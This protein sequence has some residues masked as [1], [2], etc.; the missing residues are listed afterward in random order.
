MKKYLVNNVY[1]KAASAND[2]VKQYKMQDSVKDSDKLKQMAYTFA[3]MGN[4]FDRANS[5]GS[6]KILAKEDDRKY[7][8][9]YNYGLQVL[10][11]LKQEVDDIK[12]FAKEDRKFYAHDNQTTSLLSDGASALYW[13][14]SDRRDQKGEVL[15]K[16]IQALIKDYRF[17]AMQKD[18]VKDLYNKFERETDQEFLKEAIAE[19]KRYERN[20]S[21]MEAKEKRNI[22]PNGGIKELKQNIAWAEQR[23][24]QL[25]SGAKDSKAKDFD[26]I[27]DPMYIKELQKAIELIKIG[28]YKKAKFFVDDVS[29][30]LEGKI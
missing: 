4:Y 2:A 3:Q 26:A 15:S 25:Q 17:G 20:W 18:S 23:L 10:N 29:N 6:R 1:I 12:K 14:A 16:K 5:A 13:I 27:N 21:F 22:A 28:D 7:A 24:K 8:E 19:M 30:L 11:Q 9:F